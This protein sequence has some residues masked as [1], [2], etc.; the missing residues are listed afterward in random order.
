MAIQNSAK[1]QRT[2]VA[3]AFLAPEMRELNL[4]I[5][6]IIVSQECERV[7]AVFAEIVLGED[8]V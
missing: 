4:R 6:Q 7:R 1:R 2:I 5:A 8:I 3:H